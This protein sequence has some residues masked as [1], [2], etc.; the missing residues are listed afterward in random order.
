MEYTQS[1]IDNLDHRQKSGGSSY[2]KFWTGDDLRPMITFKDEKGKHYPQVFLDHK[3]THSVEYITDFTRHKT[4]CFYV[5]D[6]PFRYVDGNVNMNKA[7]TVTSKLG[8]EVKRTKRYMKPLEV[9]NSLEKVFKC[10]YYLTEDKYKHFMLNQF[11]HK[12]RVVSDE[13]VHSFNYNYVATELVPV[14]KEE[15]KKSNSIDEYFRTKNY[16]NTTNDIEQLAVNSGLTYKQIK[17]LSFIDIYNACKYKSLRYVKLLKATIECRDYYVEN[18]MPI[19]YSN[20]G[21]DKNNIDKTLEANIKAYNKVV[22][23]LDS[24]RK[25]VVDR[26][27]EA[28]KF[29]FNYMDSNNGKHPSINTI[30]KAVGGRKKILKSAITAAVSYKSYNPAY[31]SDVF[32]TSFIDNKVDADE[33]LSKKRKIEINQ[34]EDFKSIDKYPVMAGPRETPFYKV[35]TVLQLEKFIGRVVDYYAYYNWKMFNYALD[36]KEYHE[37][38]LSQNVYRKEDG[39]YAWNQAIWDMYCDEICGKGTG[40]SF[41]DAYVL[42]NEQVKPEED[43]CDLMERVRRNMAERMKDRIVT[44]ESDYNV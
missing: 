43:L 44:L 11:N 36:D 17:K 35:K 19:A 20:L 14:W 37:E 30:H 38:L 15:I 23:G 16:I 34:D 26:V 24:V 40:L 42:L 4:E 3:I 29:T 5:Y 9:L 1:I 6:T 7:I 8:D 27:S 33:Q 10:A 22:F 12:I 28:V 31:W 41:D 25:D 32:K 21:L 18:F 39:G 2:F 13:S